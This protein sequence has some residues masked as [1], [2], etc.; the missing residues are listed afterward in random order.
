MVVE[1][2]LSIAPVVGCSHSRSRYAYILTT[3]FS[4]GIA[5][6]AI[7]QFIVDDRS[8]NGFPAWWGN[9]IVSAG[10]DGGGDS[11]YGCPRLAIP[12]EGFFHPGP[13]EF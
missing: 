10:C 13:G 5:I 1:V 8:V 6:S 7:F 12:D 9:D 2:R 3:A 4:V 11:G